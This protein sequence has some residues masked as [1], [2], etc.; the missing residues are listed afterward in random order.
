M[1]SN[2]GIVAF[3]GYVPQLRLKR[4]AIVAANAWANPGLKSAG[5]GERAVAS[6]DE[7]VVTMAVEASRDA[8]PAAQ[9]E[10][11]GGLILASTT[12]PFADRLNAGIV[13]GALGLGDD[14]TGLDVTGTVRAGTSALVAGQA[15]AMQSERPV[16][17]ASAE[18][19]RAKV[20]SALELA[21]GDAAAAVVLGTENVVA[22]ILATHSLTRDFVDH[23]RSMGEP[24]EYGWEERWVREEGYMKLLPA[25]AKVVLGKAGVSADQITTLIVPSPLARIESAVA[26]KI[27][28]PDGAITDSLSA[29]LG[30][31]GAA[32][33]LVLLSL[34]LETAK[35]GD[36]ILVLGFGNGCDA[37]VIE[38]TDAITGFQPRRGVSGWLARGRSTDEYMRYLSFNTEVDIEWGARAEFGNKYALTMEYRFSRD[39]LGF[40]G[41]RDTQTGV[42][43]FPKTPMA[44]AP[45]AEGKATY[46]DVPLADLSARVVACTADW[47]TYHPSPP[48]YFGLVQFDNGARVAMEFVDVASGTIEVGQ[49]V[50]MMFRVKEIDRMRSYRH[51]FWKATPSGEAAEELREAAE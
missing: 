41:G 7:D 31:A 10:A 2:V 4:S 25:A 21:N 9:R 24:H 40:I 22:R 26:K 33:G 42:V 5:K 27:G 47:L 12:P 49:S 19:R 44:V 20:G 3:G 6:W 28:V 11:L 17:V 36:R 39:M 1:A 14:V 35:P 34:A 32:H 16:L 13:A 18:R 50:E 43:Q 23:F 15:L 30:Y 37:I 45:N 29:R 46:D 8:M 38:A 48:L 51:Y